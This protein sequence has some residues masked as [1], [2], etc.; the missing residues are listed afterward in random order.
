MILRHMTA[1]IL[2]KNIVKVSKATISS[3]K[4]LVETT[5][6]TGKASVYKGR[7]VLCHCHVVFDELVHFPMPDLQ[8][9]VV[10]SSVV[11]LTET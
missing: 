8:M 4:I 11:Y 3:L 7:L 9:T 5:E 2:M 1:H 6:K 10:D